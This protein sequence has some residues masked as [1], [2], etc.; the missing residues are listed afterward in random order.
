MSSA[1][2]VFC[3]RLARR[4]ALSRRELAQTCCVTLLTAL[5]TYLV[6]GGVMLS[7]TV[8]Y[9]ADRVGR[10][11][12]FTRI[13]MGPKAG[14]AQPLS[15]VELAA[16]TEA[17]PVKVVVPW[18]SLTAGIVVDGHAPVREVHLRSTVPGDPDIRLSKGRAAPAG[19]ALLLTDRKAE[20]LGLRPG[21]PPPKITIVF[22]RE[23]YDRSVEQKVEAVPLVVVR[24]EDVG[25][26]LY[27]GFVTLPLA[28][29][30]ANWQ[31]FDDELQPLQAA[32]QAIVHA[33]GPGA[34]RGVDAYLRKVYQPRGYE[35]LSGLE[36]LDRYERISRVVTWAAA[37]LA[38]VLA[39]AWVAALMGLAHATADR[40]RPA[41]QDLRLA[42]AS[43]AFL[44]VWLVVQ[45]GGTACA[46][47]AAGI[48]VAMVVNPG[49]LG[50]LLEA[51]GEPN[52][53]RG[54]A[55]ALS[56]VLVGAGAALLASTTSAWTSWRCVS[57]RQLGS[58]GRR[59]RGPRIH[60]EPPWPGPPV[61]AASSC[62]NS[63][64]YRQPS[65]CH[66]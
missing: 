41:V 49:L 34:V 61:P 32:P 31:R 27:Q 14:W 8:G 25:D 37:G 15:L 60:K 43:P 26:R 38:G 44:R 47:I 22:R 23:R 36:E 5:L 33:D 7:R 65:R 57:T 18:V 52:T 51:F 16:L 50:E 64:E 11:P 4:F 53:A 24:A 56:A 10:E 48:A 59:R 20:E 2:L 35:V 6:T 63:G 19:P 21:A 3:G 45:L 66:D 55:V 12:R 30:V 62:L 54:T 9:M 40:A 39:V 58:R 17:A 13:V 1:R 46:G 29:R 42:G 28:S